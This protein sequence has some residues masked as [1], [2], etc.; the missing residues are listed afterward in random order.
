MHTVTH[1]PTPP[2]LFSS[3]EVHVNLLDFVVGSVMSWS[4]TGYL[5]QFV[6]SIAV[7][8]P[9]FFL[10]CNLENDVKTSNLLP[11]IRS[12]SLKKSRTSASPLADD[13]ATVPLRP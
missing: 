1:P 12:K 3:T 11:F 8:Q 6:I 10:Q 13:L 7:S 4:R 9:Y 5:S 2:L